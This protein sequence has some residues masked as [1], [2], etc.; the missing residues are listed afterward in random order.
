M[1][2]D[3]QRGRL[4]LTLKQ[5]H[6]IRQD[7]TNEEAHRLFFRTLKPKLEGFGLDPAKVYSPSPKVS[8]IRLIS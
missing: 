3:N 6:K 4:L 2:M 5:P 7:K 8:S 1:Y